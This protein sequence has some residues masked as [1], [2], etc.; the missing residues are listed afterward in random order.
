MIGTPPR[1]GT[2]T[3]LQACFFL[4]PAPIIRFPTN[5]LL[6]LLNNS[7]KLFYISVP[8][9]NNSMKKLLFLA[10][11]LAFTS[12]NAQVEKQNLADFDKE[13]ARKEAVKKGVPERVM[14]EY[15]HGQQVR[16]ENEHAEVH[17]N[18]KKT[19]LVT[20]A[21]VNTNRIIGQT[22]QASACGNSDLAS[23]N[24][25]GWTGETSQNCSPGT[26]YPV[27]SWSGLGINANNG[28]PIQLNNSPCNNLTG[29]QVIHN[30]P[31]GAM[32]T[33]A[34]TAFANG[35]DDNCKNPSTGLYDL[36][37]TPANGVNSIRLS[38]AYN[39]YTCAKLSY[40]IAVTAQNAQFTYQFAVVIED[41]THPQ[42][43]QPSFLFG[44]KSSPGGPLV[45]GVNQNCVEYNIDAS[46]AMNDTTFIKANGPCSGWDVYYRKWR[47]VTI[48]LTSQIGNTVYAEFETLDC[49]WSGHYAYAYISAT[50]GN[51]TASVS[52]FCGGVGSATMQAPSGFASYQWYGPNNLNPIAGATSS[53][54]TANPAV[55][56]DVF[57]VDCITLQGCTTKLT[58]TVA[59][60]NILSTASATPTC[61]GGSTGTATVTVLSGGTQYSYQWSTGPNDTLTSISNLPPG[62]Y[63]V[64]VHDLTLNCPD[65]TI[66]VTVSQINP[67]LQ[68][69]TDTLCGSTV[70]INGPTPGTNYNWYQGS[71]SSV[72]ATSTNYT[73]TNPS[74]GDNYTLS[75]LNSTT[76]CIDSIKTTLYINTINFS[77]LSSNPCTGGNTGSIGLTA[78]QG[79]SF[80]NY[81][82][83]VTSTSTVSVSY[84]TATTGTVDILSI[85]A[86]TYTVTITEVGNPTC[87][88]IYTVTLTGT[89]IPPAVLDTIK[90]CPGDLVN[91]QP[92]VTAG[93]THTWYQNGS[94][95]A[96]NFT[97]SPL[98]VSGFTTSTIYTDTIRNAF[99]CKSVYKATFKIRS[100][101][102]TITAPEKIKCHDD[103]T[104]KLKVTINTETNG[105]LGTP[106]VF[107]WN[108]PNP[109]PDPTPTTAGTGV[110]QSSLVQ[111]LHAGTYTCT[112]T[113]GGCTKTFTYNLTNP[114]LLL[115]DSLYAYFCPKD[116]ITWLYAEPGHSVY[117]WMNVST[118]TP[119]VISGNNNDSIEVTPATVEDYWV[120]YTIAGCRDT[121]RVLFTYPSY[122]AFRPDKIVNIFTPNGDKRNDTFYPFY[123]ANVSQYQIDKQMEDYEIVIYNRW[124]KKVHESNSYSTAWNGDFEGTPQDDGTYYYILRYKS[125]CSTKADIIEKHGFVQLL[126]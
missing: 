62:N 13:K 41:G 6:T 23:N 115:D 37:L 112:V 7:E 39:N 48:D 124:G 53:V 117:T 3:G 84:P 118:G 66:A 61:R 25:S 70:V 12:L 29:F 67:P 64:T 40:S 31:I 1:R 99:G 4:F 24:Y 78:N 87:A 47:T 122:H 109:Y 77:P 21:E 27:A 60:S 9:K 101:N 20:Y 91:L 36:S 5:F 95:V 2:K 89:G 107:T 15:L 18:E 57:T 58:V 72:I 119:V 54:Y 76:G 121:A 17:L 32:S 33:N 116:S 120:M 19:T 28:T 123:D 10:F 59:A 90:A 111:T 46:G 11:A 63:N 43:E 56:G 73:V 92:N 102:G 22:I 94:L 100:F 85:P 52:G 88:Y 35:Y 83:G 74:T 103:S 16:F 97:V 71:G 26:L 75:Y 42:G 8:K 30:Q 81:S 55:N 65:T 38:S 45:S 82:Y 68:Q 50:C 104:G 34:G 108:Y 106:Y 125:N 86:G 93:S 110:P 126:R 96:P 44:V 51:L 49:P 80:N 98:S 114:A 113:S 79:N 69:L 14:E 105:P